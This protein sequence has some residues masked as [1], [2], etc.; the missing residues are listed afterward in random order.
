MC[1]CLCTCICLLF[2]VDMYLHDGICAYLTGNARMTQWGLAVWTRDP[3]R[4]HCL[5]S[6]VRVSC[7]GLPTL[8][9]W[10]PDLFAQQIRASHVMSPGCHSDSVIS[11]SCKE[12]NNRSI[13]C[14]TK[15]P[16]GFGLEY[17]SLFM[18]LC[19]AS[20]SSLS[21]F[22]YMLKICLP[23]CLSLS[24]P[25]CLS[26]CLFSFSSASCFP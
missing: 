7:C 25:L 9:A 26:F 2:C 23:V 19:L 12:W 21:V 18:C 16:G 5:T 6:A 10:P 17:Y 4:H 24:V 15:N 11:L 13:S 20:F 14:I 8:P 1:F 22:F 3:V